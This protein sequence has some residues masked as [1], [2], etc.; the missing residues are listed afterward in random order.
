MRVF[1]VSRVE[2]IFKIRFE[3]EAEAV[4]RALVLDEQMSERAD[5]DEDER[6]R[7]LMAG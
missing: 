7:R 6:P 4:I 3:E 1:G 2:T 5:Y